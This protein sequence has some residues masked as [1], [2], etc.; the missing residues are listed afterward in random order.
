MGRVHAL[1]PLKDLELAKRRLAD[2]LDTVERRALVCAMATDVLAVL[3]RHSAVTDIHVL[4]DD[5]DVAILVAEAG[6]RYWS[7]AGL[8]QHA[9]KATRPRSETYPVDPLNRVLQAAAERVATEAEP[10]DLT[11]VLHADLPCLSR[12]DIDTVLAAGECGRA[13][14]LGCDAE[15]I[16]SNLLLFASISPPVFQ[17]GPGSAKAHQN[18]AEA[19]KIP[20]RCLRL[21]GIASDTDTP[22]DLRRLRDQAPGPRTAR[23]LRRRQHEDVRSA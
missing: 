2:V 22:E 17:F 11:L 15:G 4:S 23:W 19:Q 16:G 5:S 20:F 9:A 12:Q 8:L 13:I 1:V 10:G 14:V 3:T 7:E 21:P 6:A 18:W